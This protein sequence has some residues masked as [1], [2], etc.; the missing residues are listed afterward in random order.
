MASSGSKIEVSA[1]LRSFWRPWG[2]T[3]SL[4]FQLPGASSIPWLGEGGLPPSSRAAPLSWNSSRLFCVLPGT[5]HTESAGWLFPRMFLGGACGACPHSQGARCGQP[6]R[7]A[8]SA[9]QI[10]RHKH[11]FVSLLPTL[12]TNG[13]D[14]DIFLYC[15]GI[16]SP[17]VNN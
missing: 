4:P 13:W 7:C 8:S 11:R 17:F 14:G 9:H 3:A 5:V 12:L 15:H 16:F 10:R 2:R 6:H 1:G